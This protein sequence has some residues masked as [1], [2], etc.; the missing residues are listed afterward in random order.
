MKQFIKYLLSILSLTIG[1]LYLCD[2]I[3]TKAYLNANPRNKLQ[4]ILKT[5]GKKFD[6]VFL[7]SSR[8]ANHIDTKLF[9]SLSQKKT[10]NL[11][12]EG[13]GLNDNLLQLK[14]LL[15]KNTVSNIFLQID[16]NFEG[17][18]PSNI[19]ISE[20]MPF[21]RNNIIKNHLKDNFKN[22][23]K[24][25]YL[26]FYRYA[27]NDPKIG[28]REFI[29]SLANKK[30][31]VNSS[32][33]FTPMYGKK[34]PFKGESLPENIRKSNKVLEEIIEICSKYNISLTLYISP[35]CSKT[36]NLDYITKLKKKVPG[37]IDLS[38]G[39]NDSLFYNC[40]H[41]NRKGA[42]IFTVDLFNATKN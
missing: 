37:L 26:P 10:I 39:Y 33:G 38:S 32:T 27:V 13:A 30:P 16:F 31:R 29:F 35:F 22:F 18:S 19:S 9:N 5:E 25:Q 8:V 20:A 3:Y 1:L 14:L 7:G 2:F 34:L 6:I 24:L 23:N 42:E 17:V 41:L 28:F 36:N 11:G 4:Y 15:D 21:L 12:V 40:G